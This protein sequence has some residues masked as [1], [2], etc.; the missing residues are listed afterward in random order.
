MLKP[1]AA[2]AASKQ[3]YAMRKI[4]PTFAAVAMLALLACADTSQAPTSGGIGGS[5]PT[6]VVASPA[7]AFPTQEQLASASAI[8]TRGEFKGDYLTAN[9]PV[10]LRIAFRDP[11]C[12]FMWDGGSNRPRTVINKSTGSPVVAIGFHS[13]NWTCG[14]EYTDE[15][16]PYVFVEEAYRLDNRWYFIAKNTGG[17]R[18][19]CSVSHVSFE[20][21]DSWCVEQVR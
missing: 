1:M 5:T 9:H 4:L 14:R 3:E 18:V 6:T 7:I 10:R 2:M 12:L 11:R 13:A 8:I 19:D 20:T 21:E 15:L 17:N 16:V